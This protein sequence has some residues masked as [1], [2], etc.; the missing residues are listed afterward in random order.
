MFQGVGVTVTQMKS[1]TIRDTTNTNRLVIKAIVNDEVIFIIS[2]VSFT[3][4]STDPSNAVTGFDVIKKGLTLR[5]TMNATGGVTST[6]DYYWGTAS[7]SLKLG[8][9]SASDFA[10]AGRRSNSQ[11]HLQMLVLPVSQAI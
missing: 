11:L 4:D 3:I 2:A 10:L 5:N 6:T 8:G 9:Y 7:N 1:A